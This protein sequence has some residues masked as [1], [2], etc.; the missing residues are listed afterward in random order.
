MSKKG[1][2]AVNIIS[3][4]AHM[5]CLCGAHIVKVK[6]PTSYLEED[7]TKDVFIKNNIQIDSVVERVKII[8]DMFLSGNI[9]FQVLKPKI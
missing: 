1:E 3:Y 4:A 7:S 9:Y 5:A 8:F 6:L 2:T